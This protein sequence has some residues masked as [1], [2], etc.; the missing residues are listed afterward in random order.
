MLYRA[1]CLAAIARW[2]QGWPSMAIRLNTC[3]A[4]VAK[5]DIISII[6]I[7]LLYTYCT[8]S[9]S[10]NNNSYKWNYTIYS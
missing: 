2:T 5:V 3:I 1:S 7:A 9:K 10:D 6:I 8:H 4:Y